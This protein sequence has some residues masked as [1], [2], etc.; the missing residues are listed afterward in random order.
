MLRIDK[1]EVIDEIGRGGMGAV[2][3]SFHP[4]LKKYIA[5]KE[6]RP[7]IASDPEIKRLFE[8]EAE[9]LANLP[10]HPHLVTIRDAFLWEGRLYLVMDY[11]EG[12]TLG[13][14]IEQGPVDPARGAAG[15][16]PT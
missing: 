11:L 1:Y 12:G 7:E 15:P 4:H 3:K 16:H 9:L 2:Y 10:S 8:R 6:I 13:D 14:L 5:I